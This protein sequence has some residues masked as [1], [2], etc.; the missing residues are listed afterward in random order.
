MLH[1]LIFMHM[2]IQVH[3]IFHIKIQIWWFF[4]TKKYLNTIRNS[5]HFTSKIIF[6]GHIVNGVFFLKWSSDKCKEISR[7][8]V[9]K[10]PSVQNSKFKIR[11][12]NQI[13]RGSQPCI[14]FEHK[15][16]NKLF[17]LP[18]DLLLF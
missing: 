9:F 16:H 11:N 1:I 3:L 6:H 7:P 4:L 2:C 12:C 10:F 15:F 8:Q 17:A 13:F 5:N 14:R 18:H